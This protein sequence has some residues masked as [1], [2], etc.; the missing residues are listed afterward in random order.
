MNTKHQ[1]LQASGDG[2]YLTLPDKAVQAFDIN[3]K[4]FFEWE[5]KRGE[6]IGRFSKAESV[7]GTLT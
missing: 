1:Q 6:I 2:L 5:N 7:V 4:R 3:T